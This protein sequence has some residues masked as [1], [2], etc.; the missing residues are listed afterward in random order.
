MVSVLEADYEGPM[1]R[2]FS[3]AAAASPSSS[4]SD[5]SVS[6]LLNPAEFECLQ[7]KSLEMVQLTQ[8]VGI[9]IQAKQFPC[10]GGASAAQPPTGYLITL[11]GNLEGVQTTH[12]R[13]IEWIIRAGIAAS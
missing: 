5:I 11:T 3:A 13:V 1:T 6:F 8:S 4:T 12:R 7:T 10:D 2:A 9:N